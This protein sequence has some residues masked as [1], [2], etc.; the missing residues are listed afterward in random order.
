MCYTFV[1]GDIMKITDIVRKYKQDDFK[2]REF[3]EVLNEIANYVMYEQASKDKIKYVDV[4]KTP[5]GNASNF[6]DFIRKIMKG[7]FEY[8]EGKGIKRKI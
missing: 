5:I 6:V 7:T 2:D 4:L 8:E 1:S 3:V